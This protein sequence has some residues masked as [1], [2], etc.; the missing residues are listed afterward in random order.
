MEEEMKSP[1]LD[2]EL[3]LSLLSALANWEQSETIAFSHDFMRLGDKEA[4]AS[5]DNLALANPVVQEMLEHRYLSPEPDLEYLASLPEETLGNQFEAMLRSKGLDAN[6][7]RESAFIDAHRK[8]GEDVGYVAERGWQLHDLYHVLTGWDT[9]PIGE[10][11]VVSF[12]VAQTPAPY[13][14]LTM[15][16][17]PL[18]AAL[19]KPELLPIL[20]DAISEGWTLGRRTPP[21]INIHWEDFWERPLAEI[22]K[23]LGLV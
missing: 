10:V 5:Y 20:F 22:Q 11:K 6:M 1:E 13:P 12:T 15:T 23:E 9:S 21:L 18:Q 2:P 4:L 17:R 19:Y 16:M 3:V 14:A 8:R 7:L